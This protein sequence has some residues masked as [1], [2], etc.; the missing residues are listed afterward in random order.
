[1]VVRGVVRVVMS[2][3][4]FLNDGL[5][6]FVEKIVATVGF[7]LREFLALI[8]FDLLVQV[9]EPLAPFDFLGGFYVV[10][11]TNVA[12]EQIR[13]HGRRDLMLVNVT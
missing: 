13:T 9:V 8:L 3:E 6:F 12:E 10:L 7:V 11:V 1:M 4:C 2:F 5:H